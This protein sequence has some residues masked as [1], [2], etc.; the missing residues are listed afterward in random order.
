MD[1]QDNT[2]MMIIK[3]NS[4]SD[5]GCAVA[6]VGDDPHGNEGTLWGAQNPVTN[7]VTGTAGCAQRAAHIACLQSTTVISVIFPLAALIRNIN[8]VV[9]PSLT[10]A[11]PLCCIS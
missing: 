3:I 11:D 5:L 4:S 9:H 2:D 7:M 10:T 1:A 6:A 8:A